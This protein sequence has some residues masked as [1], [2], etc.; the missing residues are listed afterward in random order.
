MLPKIQTA[1]EK[2]AKERKARIWM[3]VIVVVILGASTAAYALMETQSSEKAKYKE[4][5][6]TRTEGGWRAK[7]MN[8]YA[9]YLPQDVEN[10]TVSG[11]LNLDDFSGTAYIN[12]FG[13]ADINVANELIRTMPLEKAVLSCAPENENE[14]FCSDLPIKS[15]SDA[16][17]GNPIISFEYSNET[18]VSYDDF[19]L[20]ISTDKE[21]SLKAADRAIYGL[22]KII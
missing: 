9:T 4:L 12:A 6:F 3:T 22:Y 8:F 18:S 14:S 13:A 1:S 20:V 19:C 2:E 5:T 11:N 15:C 7:D 16:S 21:N 10:I 17:E